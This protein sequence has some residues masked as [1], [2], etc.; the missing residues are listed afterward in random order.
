MA[1]AKQ[2]PK[3]D[4]VTLDALIGD[5]KSPEHF[6][7]LMRAIQKRLAERMLAGEPTAHL[8]YAPGAPKPEG[9]ANYRNGAAPKTVLTDTG[10]VP[11]EIPRLAREPFARPAPET[12]PRQHCA[13]APQEVGVV[14]AAAPR[15]GLR[16]DGTPPPARRLKC[17]AVGTPVASSVNAP[18]T[19][20]PA[21]RYGPGA[22]KTF[23]FASYTPLPA[24]ASQDST[25]TP[26]ASARPSAGCWCRDSCR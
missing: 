15:V 3:F 11:P 2:V 17:Q 25:V 16:A 24:A 14:V 13:H 9:Q 12:P 18:R 21:S 10:A 1:N 26:A 8:G 4:P 20:A 19:V 23:P 7:R 6:V 5:A 22:A